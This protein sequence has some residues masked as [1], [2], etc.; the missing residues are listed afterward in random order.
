[1][2]QH[3]ISRQQILTTALSTF[4]QYGD[5]VTMQ[6]VAAR[7]FISPGSLNSYFSHKPELIRQLVDLALTKVKQPP[8]ELSYL[9]PT[10]E[11]RV[12]LTAYSESFTAFSQ[13]ALFDLQRYYPE[14]WN[15]VRESRA[16]QWQRIAATLETGAASCRLRPVNTNLF[17]MMVDGMLLEPFLQEQLLL[18][19]LIDILLFGITR[20]TP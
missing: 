8:A 5:A 3:R 9:S 6:Q 12:L 18:P 11:L 13:T 2:S 7:L 1:M 4:N 15:R 20:R 10:D 19:E 14:E 17:R 16:S